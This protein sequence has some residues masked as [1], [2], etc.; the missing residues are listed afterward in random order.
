MPDGPARDL[1]IDATLR[2][3]AP[4]QVARGRVDGGR[5]ILRAADLRVKVRARPTRHL[6]LFVVDA[7][8][9]MGARRRMAQTKAAVLSLLVDAYQK[10]D[11]VGLITFGGTSARLALAPT[12]S[13]R[14]AARELADLPIGGATPLAHGLALASRV[15]ETGRPPRAGRGP[16]GRPPDRRPGERPAR[17][18]RRPDR[19]RP[20]RWPTGWAATASRAWSSTP[21]A[22]RSGSGWPSGLARAWGADLR[23]LDDLGGRALPDA[24]RRALFRRIA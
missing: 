21:R 7:S 1:A 8:R 22:V 15:V 14:V 16:A 2:A 11:R 17:S 24:V 4:W 6:I 3:S 9:S 10:R 23:P 5:L 20:R 18:G 19:R 12:R 13:V